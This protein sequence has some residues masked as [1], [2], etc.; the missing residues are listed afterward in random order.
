MRNKRKRRRRRAQGP[1]ICRLKFICLILVSFDV[2]S[3]NII[4][5]LFVSLYIIILLICR[6]RWMER[7]TTSKSPLIVMTIFPHF[8]IFKIYK[9][10]P[11]LGKVLDKIH[12]NHQ[13]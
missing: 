6:E 10:F 9:Q 2:D 7:D 5:K 8:E 1:I 11:N 4:Y 3:T 12:I 13:S